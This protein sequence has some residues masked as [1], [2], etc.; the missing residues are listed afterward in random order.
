MAKVKKLDLRFKEVHVNIKTMCNGLRTLEE[1]GLKD[2]L[3]ILMLMDQTGLNKTQVRSILK[4][5][6]RLEQAYLK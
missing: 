3:L 6:P 5:L 4:A 2:D 1:C